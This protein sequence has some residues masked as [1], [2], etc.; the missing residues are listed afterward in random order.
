MAQA[1]RAR[2]EALSLERRERA[3]KANAVVSNMAMAA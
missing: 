3:A 1:S 2:P